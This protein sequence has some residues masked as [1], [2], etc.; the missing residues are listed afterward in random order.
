MKVA[1]KAAVKLSDAHTMDITR[2][3]RLICINTKKKYIQ[4][5]ASQKT[6]AVASS[7]GAP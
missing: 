4:K 6:D 5:V 7:I 3:V 2:K 1:T